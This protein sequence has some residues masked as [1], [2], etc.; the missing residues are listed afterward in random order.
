[1]VKLGLAVKIDIPE[2]V[3][4]DTVNSVKRILGPL[5]AIGDLFSEQ[6]RFLR[7][8]SAVKTL[9]RAA[10]IAKDNGVRPK[11]L[12]RVQCIK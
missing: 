7:Y 12:R 2:D 1:M 8:R 11:E 4:R 6:V 3:T 5:V 9:N 10:E